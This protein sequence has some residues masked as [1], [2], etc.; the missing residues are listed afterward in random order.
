MFDVHHHLLYGLDDGPKTLEDSIAQAEAAAADGITHVVCTPH[1]SHRYDFL[2]EVN[3]ERLAELRAV[4]AERNIPLTLAQGCDFHITY[5]NIEDAKKHPS[6]YSINGKQYILIELPEQFLQNAVSNAQTE[7]MSA[8][9]IP[10]LTH[11]ERNMSIQ[12]DPGRIRHWVADGM[13]VQVTAGSL[14]G[15]FGKTARAISNRYVEDHWA[16][17]VATDA[18]NTTSR[19]PNLRPAYQYLSQNF[20]E[21]TARRLCITNPQRIFEGEAL[22]PQPYPR[23]IDDH[24]EPS[25]G[26]RGGFLRR[27]F[28]R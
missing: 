6:R 23:G 15:E 8:R 10:V 26:F 25:G 20:G 3:A 9:M 4:L 13:L 27:L 1:A 7:L 24:D 2:P 12:R 5:D 22:G 14:L 17:I 18:H 21:E 19:P 28:G 16:T 11:P